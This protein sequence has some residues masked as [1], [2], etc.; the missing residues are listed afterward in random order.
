[1]QEGKGRQETREVGTYERNVAKGGRER[2]N[3]TSIQGGRG[4]SVIDLCVAWEAWHEWGQ[5][6]VWGL[7]EAGL[8]A[9]HRMVSGTLKTRRKKD[10]QKKAKKKAWRRRDKGD[11]S[12]W[13]E[14]VEV[15]EERMGGWCDELMDKITMLEDEKKE[16]C[17]EMWQDWLNTHNQ[18]AEAG[19]GYQKVRKKKGERK[20]KM[21]KEIIE[22][23]NKK[24]KLRQ[25]LAKKRGD[26]R[27]MLWQEHNVMKVKLKNMVR[28]ERRKREREWS[29]ELEKL[30]IGD[31]REYWA[32][33]GNMAGIGKGGRDVPNEM[34]KGEGLVK[35][36]EA[37][38][39][40]RESFE[41]LG[42]A[43]GGEEWGKQE[44]V[45][46]E[47]D[48]EITLEEVEKA[49]TELRRGKAPGR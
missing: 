49:M 25:V 27:K 48:D 26:E 35:G 38:G 28:K 20:M 32:R 36:E 46:G 19:I 42:R 18:V 15:S 31:S 24:N 44:E 37:L 2:A 3:Y 7:V 45:E 11:K 12:F 5:M 21:N 33:L 22:L 23:V 8:N 14:L 6:K 10:D 40:W 47:L 41:K 30:K 16:V 34:R 9:D 17:E 43:D 39:V 1:M 4:E 13:E 29:K